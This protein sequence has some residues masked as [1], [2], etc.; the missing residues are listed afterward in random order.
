MAGYS[1]EDV[2]NIISLEH[3]NVQIAD[4]SMATLFYV[5]GLGGTRDPYLNVGLTNMW[6]NVGE[7]QFHL[8]TRK[9]QVIDGYIGLVVPDLTAL[10]KRLALVAEGLKGSKFCYERREDYMLVTC[11][12]GNRYRCHASQPAFGDMTLGMPYVEFLVAPGTMDGILRFY[13]TV[14]GAPSTVETDGVGKFGS[15]KIGRQQSL[16]FRETERSLA[17]YDGHHVAIYVANFSGPYGYLQSRGLI[18]EDV[19][20]HQFRFKDIVDPDN[21]RPVFTLEHEVRSLR[22]PMY[23]RSF[24]NRDAAQSQREYRRGWDAFTPFQR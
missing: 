3:V 8:P 17:P 20:N 4:Q 18:S 22:H 14:F 6:V 19:R 2:G 24:V 16:W 1:E 9:P 15:V 23:H 7:Q 12:W 21:G 5:V 11:P 10:E 13:R